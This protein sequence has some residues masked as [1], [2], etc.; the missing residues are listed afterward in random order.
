M[1]IQFFFYQLKFIFGPGFVK[2]LLSWLIL[3]RNTTLTKPFGI[4]F[5]DFFCMSE[6]FCQLEAKERG[7]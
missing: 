7:E 3:K 6:F 5:L 1:I 2:Y 4:Y